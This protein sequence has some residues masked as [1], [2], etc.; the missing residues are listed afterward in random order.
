M[1][2]NDKIRKEC[3]TSNHQNQRSSFPA[4]QLLHSLIDKHFDCPSTQKDNGLDLILLLVATR[5]RTDTTERNEAARAFRDERRCGERAR[6]HTM[7][8]LAFGLTILLSRR[9]Y[10]DLAYDS[11]EGERLGQERG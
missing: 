9:S 4:K 1:S 10:P 2:N 6:G 3:R 5:L 7:V 11:I 8:D